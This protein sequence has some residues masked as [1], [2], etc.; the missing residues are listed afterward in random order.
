M[1]F[2][3]QHI[4]GT[5]AYYQW[6]HDNFVSRHPQKTVPT[7]YLHYGLLYSER[8]QYITKSKLSARG[9]QWID[10]VMLNL[11]TLLEKRLSEPDG[12]EFEKNAQALKHFAFSSH[13]EAYWNEKGSAPLHTLRLSDLITI[14]LTPNFRDL[15]SVDGIIQIL[16]TSKKLGGHYFF[17]WGKFR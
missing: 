10:E 1:H 5:P 3:P 15:L 6:R 13:V 8:F 12:I 9:Q 14:L 4:L 11:Q 2:A 17:E 16:L 7:Y